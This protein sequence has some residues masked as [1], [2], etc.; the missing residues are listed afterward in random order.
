MQLFSN[1][2]NVLLRELGPRVLSVVLV[3]V[4]V[5]AIVSAAIYSLA[6]KKRS[7]YTVRESFVL[8]LLAAS[9][10]VAH[11]VGLRSVAGWSSAVNALLLLAL[12]FATQRIAIA[13][14]RRNGIGRLEKYRARR[15]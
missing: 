2:R 1:T 14:F 4:G 13:E 12:V 8:L 11:Y 6:S 7:Y 5:A 10:A 9:L 15:R 3:Y